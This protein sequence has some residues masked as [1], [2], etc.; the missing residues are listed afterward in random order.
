MN[1]DVEQDIIDRTRRNP[2]YRDTPFGRGAQGAETP[3]FHRRRSRPVRIGDRPWLWRV[4]GIPEPRAL[5]RALI[6]DGYPRS[7]HRWAFG[8]VAAAGNWTC[9]A[10]GLAIAAGAIW[11]LDA[12]GLSPRIIL[13]AV[14][15]LGL[16]AIGVAALCYLPVLQAIR[17]ASQWQVGSEAAKKDR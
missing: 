11:F 10:V 15:G 6:I 9:L 12:A 3:V 13:L 4:L 5:V 2:A 16:A 14:V 7:L 17:Y 8:R 1:D